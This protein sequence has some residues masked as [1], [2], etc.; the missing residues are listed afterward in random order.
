LRWASTGYDAEETDRTSRL[1][2]EICWRRWSGTETMS[3]HDDRT[4]LYDQMYKRS[5]LQRRVEY[6]MANRIDMLLV[7]NIETPCTVSGR[8]MPPSGGYI[9]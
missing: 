8:S 5:K 9:L 7:H 3:I 6:E 1:I 4:I 2:L